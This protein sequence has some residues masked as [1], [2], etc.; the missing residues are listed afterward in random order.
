VKSIFP[1]RCVFI[2]GNFKKRNDFS[3]S[4]KI[5]ESPR[6]SFMMFLSEG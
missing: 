5:D 1:K 6:S 4:A 2:I 3:G